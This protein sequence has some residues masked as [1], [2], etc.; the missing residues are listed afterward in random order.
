MEFGYSAKDVA[1]SWDV[2]LKCKAYCQDAKVSGWGAKH[3]TRVW[4][5]AAPKTMQDARHSAR[6]PRFQV[7]M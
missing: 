6:V 7:M 2:W 5:C 1:E 4:G 3:D